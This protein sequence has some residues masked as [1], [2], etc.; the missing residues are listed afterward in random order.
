[1]P[2]KLK[3]WFAGLTIKAKYMIVFM[4]TTLLSYLLIVLIIGIKIEMY[5][6]RKTE[7]A[8]NLALEQ[9]VS[10][11]KA[12]TSNALYASDV[13]YLDSV[14]Y[15]ILETSFLNKQEDKGDEY[16]KWYQLSRMIRALKQET[17]DSI[18][19][20]APDN[21]LYTEQGK[22]FVGISTIMGEEVWEQLNAYGEKAVWIP[23]RNIKTEDGQKEVHS[24]LRRL[25][26]RND[27]SKTVGVIE[28][29]I[30]SEKLYHI[31]DNAN[32]SSTGCVFLTDEEGRLA[33]M[34]AR[35]DKTAGSWKKLEKKLAEEGELNW[36]R[37]KVEG[38]TYIVLS[39]IVDNVNW[40][41]TAVLPVSEL[42]QQVWNVLSFLMFL[43]IPIML[44]ATVIIY[45]FSDSFS[46]RIW[47]LSGEMQKVCE[48]NLTSDLTL[49]SRDEI[50][51]LYQVY[52][53]MLDKVDK[54]LK[55]QYEDG[56]AIKEAE[57]KALQAQINPH[58]LYNTLELIN[59]EAMENDAVEI[60][61]QVQTLAKYYRF[62]LA[63][64][65]DIICME[66]EVEQA[67]L[68]VQIQN[69][70]FDGR[71][72]CRC[73]LPEELRSARVVKLILQPLIENSILHGFSYNDIN[74]TLTIIIRFLR[75]GNDIVIAVEDNGMGMTREQ[76]VR[77]V[78]EDGGRK[79][80]YAVS[81]IH[82]RLRLKYGEQYG[83]K[84]ESILGKGTIV[85]ITIPYSM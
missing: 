34:S 8:F 44:V 71:I 78:Q 51:K 17:I 68:Y 57:I 70:R 24:L 1:M 35:G 12:E 82:N 15:D 40:K 72:D 5:E 31:L 19:I 73:E 13:L 32:V 64:G 46:K 38:S 37:I 53:F 66:Q 39:R 84:Y 9:A 28:V 10:F 42:R 26:F 49:D 62:V 6:E 16:R 33:G 29:N 69:Y 75:Q 77:I 58:F 85:Y 48:G 76:C 67:M 30:E 63:G 4:G 27:Y 20:Y 83:L 61:E 14:V 18:R 52:Q 36:Q 54:L 50:G 23:A 81:N 41:V 79:E 22:E 7:S 43:L 25:V 59:W 56:Q 65:E 55:K 80:H 11:I 3:K 74:Q 21:Y 45:S 2:E 47:R 60:S